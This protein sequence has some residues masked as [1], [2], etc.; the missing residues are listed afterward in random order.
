[1]VF[2]GNLFGKCGEKRPDGRPRNIRKYN[3]KI[4]LKEQNI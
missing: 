4:D 2:V 3:I 1:M